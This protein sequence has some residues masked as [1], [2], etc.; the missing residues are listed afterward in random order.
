M[1]WDDIAGGQPGRR[2]EVRL[3]R[4]EPALMDQGDAAV[5][6]G[7]GG[8]RIEL[9][10]RVEVGQR[11]VIVP[12]VLALVAA[13]DELIRRRRRRLAAEGG[14]LRRREVARWRADVDGGGG[15]FVQLG[16]R[17]PCV[18]R[19]DLRNHHPGAGEQGEDAVLQAGIPLELE[20]GD[21]LVDVVANDREVCPAIRQLDG[22]PRPPVV[23][24]GE[25]ERRVLIGACLALEA[26]LRA[27]VSAIGLIE[28]AVALA[29]V[30][31]HLGRAVHR[32]FHF[33]GRFVVLGL[34]RLDVDPV[35]VVLPEGP[36]ALLTIRLAGVVDAELQLLRRISA[37]LHVDVNRR[38]N[39]QPGRRVHTN[40]R[41]GARNL[42]GADRKPLE[43]PALRSNRQRPSI[44]RHVDP[45]DVPVAKAGAVEPVDRPADD[46]PHQ[47]MVEHLDHRQAFIQAVAVTGA[48]QRGFC[49]DPE[50][51]EDRQQ[52]RRLALTVAIEPRP[53][54][55]GRGGDVPAVVHAQV[56]IADPVLN[57]AQRSGG[58]D[59][60]IVRGLTDL[61]DLVAKRRVRCDGRRLL[62]QRSHQLGDL[63]PALEV[64]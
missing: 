52:E 7:D 47:D 41:I 63:R 10:G 5:R 37:Q 48:H 35:V 31:G 27:Y 53:G 50:L 55:L 45:V 13:L 51:V 34:D 61:G 22:L 20:A 54:P 6:Q 44:G 15:Q 2:R 39:A 64:A 62:V 24:V 58:L 8:F 4:I 19:R 46:R 42:G 3:R 14:F 49:L 25:S 17:R 18:L 36:Q 59:L 43:L 26:Q 21:R 16:F 12:L 11:E 9:Q 29:G 56:E 33:A 40:G 38:G 28:S 57:Q 1:K 60:G 23:R 32:Q 30:P